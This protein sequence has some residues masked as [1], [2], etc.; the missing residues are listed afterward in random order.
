MMQSAAGEATTASNGAGT[1]APEGGTLPSSDLS[2]VLDLNILAATTTDAALLARAAL[3]VIGPALGARLALWY[4][5]PA[6][7]DGWLAR[8]SLSGEAL[9][10]PGAP[11]LHLLA[12]RGL[13]SRY[14][15]LADSASEG[16]TPDHSPVALAWQQHAPLFLPDPSSSE[17]PPD[18]PALPAAWRKMARQEGLGP[19]LIVPLLVTGDRAPLGVL[20]A[21]FAPE[22]TVADGQRTALQLAAVT[23][24]TAFTQVQTQEQ[25][26]RRL[27]EALLLREI[28]QMISNSIDLEETLAAV[29]KAVRRLI[30]YSSS[31]ICLYD[32]TYTVLQ[33]RAVAGEETFVGQHS[34][35]YR[36]SEGY[37]GWV[38]GHAQPL[39]VED[40]AALPTPQ[41]VSRRLA[42]GV[43]MHAYIG[44]PLLLQPA[45]LALPDS[46][47]PMA[48]LEPVVLGTLEVAFDHP[49]AFTT[50]DVRLLEQV[51]EEAAVAIGRAQAYRESRERLDRRLQELTV[52]QRVGRELNTTWDLERI[53]DLVTREAVQATGAD[54]AGIIQLDP[55]GRGFIARSIYG[56]DQHLA[57]QLRGTLIPLTTGLVGQVLR[58][59][60]PVCVND[61]TNV[62]AYKELLPTTRSEL[63]IP[64]RYEDQIVG[65]VNLESHQVNG[66]DED[67]VRFV[68]ALAD[69]AAIAIGNAQNYEAQVEQGEQLLRRASQLSQVLEISNALIGE[70]PLE[71]VL[72]QIVHAVIE[73]AGFDAAALRM[74][75]PEAPDLLDLVA[76]AG[77]PL[78]MYQEVRQKRIP[79]GEAQELLQDENR[80]GRA[81]YIPEPNRGE[82]GDEWHPEDLLL[83]PLLSTNGEFLGILSV[84]M[85]YDHSKPT[86]NVVETLEIFANQAALAIENSQ[87]FQRY[88]ARIAEMSALNQLGQALSASLHIDAICVSIYEHVRQFI[89]VDAFYVALYDESRRVLSFPF[90]VDEG[91]RFTLGD[92]PL[93]QGFGSLV[94]QQRAPVVFADLADR[95]QWP[96]DDESYAAR[97]TFFGSGKATRGWLGVPLTVGHEIIGLISAQSYTPNAF[98]PEHVQF[99]STVANQAAVAIQNARLFNDRER[100]IGELATLNQIARELNSSLETDQLLRLLFEQVRQIMKIRFFHIVLAHPERKELEFRFNFEDG[101]MKP[102]RVEP[103]AQG[104]LVPYVMETRQ[105]LLIKGDTNDFCLRMGIERTGIGAR[106]WMG[107]PM[108]AGDRVLGV[109]VVPSYTDENAYDQDH[110]TLLS[111][112]ATQAAIALENAQLFQERERRIAELSILNEI[113]RDLTSTLDV[114][115]LLE[116]MLSHAQRATGA[117]FGSIFRYDENRRGLRPMAHTGYD[118]DIVLLANRDNIWSLDVGL[119][120]R[121]FRTGDSLLMTDVTRDPDYFAADPTVRSELLVPIRKEARVL[122]VLNLESPQVGAFDLEHQRF[123]EQLAAQTAIALENARLY[124]EAQNRILQLDTLNDLSSVL[125]SQLDPETVFETL[126]ERVSILFSPAA[127]FVGLVDKEKQVVTYPFMI[128]NE[129][130][131]HG[132]ETVL[133]EGLSSWVILRGRQLSLDNLISQGPEYGATTVAGTAQIGSWMGA[134]LLAGDEVI[135]LLSV[136]SFETGVYTPAHLQFLTTL[137]HHAAVAIQNAKLF[138]QIRSFNDQ[139]EQE[140]AARTEE[141]ADT[142][143]QLMVEK[144]RL[145]ELYNIS[146]QLSTSLELDEIVQRGLQLV[147]AVGGVTRGSILLLDPGQGALEYRAAVV[148]PGETVQPPRSVRPQDWGLLGWV[149]RERRG[150]L[151]GDVLQDPRWIPSAEWG[152]D[153]RS[154]ICVP[155]MSGDELLGLLSLTHPEPS[156]F[157]ESHFRLVSTVANEMSIAIHNATLYEYITDQATRLALALKVQEEEASNRKAI[158]ESITDGVIV[159]DARA[160]TRYQVLM[161]NAAAERMCAVDAAEILGRQVPRGLQGLDIAPDVLSLMVMLE[162]MCRFDAPAPPQQKRFTLR[163]K[164]LNLTL[165]QVVSPQ[166]EIMGGVAVFRDVTKEVEVDRMKSEFIST[167]AHELRTP[168]TSIKGYTDLILMGTVGAVSDMQTQFLTVI[169]NNADRLSVLVADILDLSRIETGRIQLN[170]RYVAISD[171]V[172][173]VVSSLANQI[174]AKDQTLSVAVADDLPDVKLDRDRIIQ[175]LTNLVSNANKYTPEG[176]SIGISARVDGPLLVVAVRDTGY[177]ISEAD[178]EKLF[179]TRFFRANNPNV[180]FVSGTGLGLV[181]ARSLVEMHGGRIWAE[182]VVEEGSTFTFTIPLHPADE[183]RTPGGTRLLGGVT[184]PLVLPGAAPPTNGHGG[185]PEAA[186]ALGADAT[187]EQIETA[188]QVLFDRE[189]AQAAREAEAADNLDDIDAGRR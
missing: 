95:A 77:V 39:V 144:E 182:S 64:I 153:I 47:W 175:V 104:G 127:F 94:V 109:I 98:R 35:E 107:V 24:A 97:R 136:Q 154:M 118:Q 162:E 111:T 12:S 159:L 157:S 126:Y 140:V 49:H 106:C 148:R 99:L 37:T 116:R 18:A 91:E 36:L 22:A 16:A 170:R 76:A 110:V 9:P 100:R 184:S 38:A 137:A 59:G 113:A 86:R 128:E 108:I 152:H 72:D 30:P 171:L 149:A 21:Y 42:G 67:A 68:E 3:D 105:P 102:S 62:S 56:L 178:L 41:P 134:P 40:V 90:G 174:T 123:V 43:T 179:E 46:D 151:I 173:D 66:F 26:G 145:E 14:H 53:F 122:G 121:V 7:R 92:S 103:V 25:M 130:R 120:G 168:M 119:I 80:I 101:Q 1:P 87:L 163:N 124:D 65:V 63:V 48:E 20:E 117:P 189:I 57:A 188:A 187:A 186:G 45:E 23:L 34:A 85:P 44:L 10:L 28:S 2:W 142:N 143:L 71:E 147:T 13:G 84:D 132:Q 158:L 88:K 15:R 169:K 185:E 176:G 55:E 160:D 27:A 83:L 4:A 131:I 96:Y 93:G 60:E 89:A 138:A 135:G 166:G 146:H 5:A 139:L 6:G 112:V 51:A 129:Q 156:Y 79:V 74:I 81:Y 32:E 19:G 114:H 180:Q 150:A 52:L 54:Y 183:A 165:S 177:G 133:G 50:N 167:V 58:T 82:V 8:A 17:T 61:V 161:L 29:L 141:L 11:P 33:T 75:T 155:L 125:S 172:Q 73:T 78:P 70:Q 164:V 31:E 69:Q 181:I 115:Q